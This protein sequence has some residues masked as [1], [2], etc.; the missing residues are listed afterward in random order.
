MAFTNY[1]TL[2]TAI[3]SWL[4]RD[5]SVTV[6]VIPDFIRLATVRINRDL[7]GVRERATQSISSEYTSFTPPIGGLESISLD[8]L[9]PIEITTM[10]RLDYIIGANGG[11]A[12]RPLF[13]TFIPSTGGGGVLRVCP[14]PDATYTA[15]IIYA[16]QYPAFTLD[17]D[18]NDILDD[19]PDLYLYGALAESAPFLKDDERAA[20]W[21]QKYKSG[22]AALKALLEKRRYPGTPIVRPR[23]ALGS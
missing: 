9:G 14:A 23:R 18:T 5:D 20:L 22:L 21:E 19:H 4:N 10:D 15:N 13:G 16:P 17:A 7:S 6:A 1:G 2:K 3:S 12:G 11:N 8:G